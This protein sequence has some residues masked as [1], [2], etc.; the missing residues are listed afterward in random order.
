MQALLFS[1]KVHSKT[2]DKHFLVFAMTLADF[3][4]LPVVGKLPKVQ[5]ILRRMVVISCFGTLGL[6][7]L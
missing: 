1:V 5:Q 2:P 6:C 7:V 3:Q 4:W